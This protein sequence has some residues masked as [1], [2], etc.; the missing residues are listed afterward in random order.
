MCGVNAAARGLAYVIAAAGWMYPAVVSAQDY[1][2]K[3]VR[4][5]VPFGPGGSPDIVGRLIADRLTRLWG[6]QVIVENRAGVA[7]VMGSAFVAKS[8]PDG[9]TLLQCNIAPNA[10][11]VSM[12][13]KLPYDQLR[14][15]VPITR[16]GSLP[17]ILLSHPSLP[18]QSVKELIAYAKAR[19]GKLS[20]SSGQV[21]TSPQLSIELLKQAAKIDIVNIPYKIGSQGLTDAI[22]GQVPLNVSNLPQSVAPVQSGRLRGLAVTSAKRAAPLPSVP[23]MQES[24]IAGYEV[25]SWYGVCAPAGTPTAVLD[26]VNAAVGTVLNSPELQQRLSELI[27]E[28]APSSRE[29]FDRFIRAE[30]ARWAQ[31]IKEAGIPQ[32]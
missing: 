7:G 6:Q 23:T 14:D 19:P 30:I 10:I 8:P 20:Y 2:S 24:G 26:K 9:Y 31:V 25:T 12:F 13:K 29:E 3:P 15:F 5:V 22:G 32:I 1:P 16:I 27:T 28:I 21:G 4:Y 17:N 11:G 18:V